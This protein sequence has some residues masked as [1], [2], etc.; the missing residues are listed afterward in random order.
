[1]LSSD[2]VVNY[3]EDIESIK[4][5]LKVNRWQEPT[6]TGNQRFGRGI[7]EKKR[8]DFYPTLKVGELGRR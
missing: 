4:L 7:F 2:D 5:L 6:R 8:S 1:M 3:A